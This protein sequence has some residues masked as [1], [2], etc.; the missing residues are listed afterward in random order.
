M[1]GPRRAPSQAGFSLIEILVVIT[2]IG[3]L[4]GLAM[5]AVGKHR[6]TGRVS[7]CRSRILAIT[8]WC[9]SYAEREGEVPPS[10]LAAAGVKDAANEVNQGIE[11]MVAVLR[12]A[13]YGGLR[14]DERWLG[15]TDADSSASL[16]ALDGSAALLEILDPWDNPFIYLAHSDYGQSSVVRL[17]DGSN[18]LDVEA[19][20]E[21]NPLT[22]AWHQ[23][24]SFQ[25]R[26]AGPDGLLGSEDD[27]ANFELP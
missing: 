12:R 11:A 1:A 4:A 23:F 2:I 16:Q 21:R 9:E 15:N 24:E 25:L 19:R 13:S 14:P 8:L 7:D 20:A 6:E 5:V 10:R 3:M 18:S 17:G 22:G 27:L 26:S